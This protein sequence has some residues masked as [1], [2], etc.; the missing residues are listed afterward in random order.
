MFEVYFVVFLV[1]AKQL[2]KWNVSSGFNCTAPSA[3][4]QTR[5]EGLLGGGGGG[6]RGGGGGGGF[7]KMQRTY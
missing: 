5:R 6:G 2:T 3:Y 7:N 1:L 4:S